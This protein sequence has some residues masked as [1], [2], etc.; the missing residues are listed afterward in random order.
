MTEDRIKEIRGK[1]KNIA[2]LYNRDEIVYLLSTISRLEAAL[3]RIANPIAWIQDEAKRTGYE[4]NGY[5]AV[6]LADDPNYLRG[7]AR[8]ALK[9]GNGDALATTS[10]V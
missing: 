7:I 1:T 5:M 6:R 4:V 9:E 10:S 8:E 2:N 3:Q